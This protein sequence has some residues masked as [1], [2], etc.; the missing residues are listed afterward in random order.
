MSV[1]QF[2]PGVSAGWARFLFP[3]KSGPGCFSLSSREAAVES[4]LCHETPK[5]ADRY[6]QCLAKCP[7]N[8]MNTMNAKHPPGG[9]AR[10]GSDH[11]W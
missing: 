8:T 1:K 10:R 4:A 3:L 9:A 2:K 11:S 6:D 5:K 7:M